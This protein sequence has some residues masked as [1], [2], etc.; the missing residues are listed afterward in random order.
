MGVKAVPANER[1]VLPTTNIGP[2]RAT[3]CLD[4]TRKL[5]RGLQNN[6]LL[7]QAVACQSKHNE[8][9]RSW[10]HTSTRM[11]TRVRTWGA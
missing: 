2:G 6:N 10:Q 11:H 4:P 3:G 7:G 1:E 9:Q 5:L 8:Y